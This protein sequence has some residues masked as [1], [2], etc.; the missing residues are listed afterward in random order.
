MPMSLSSSTIV[1]ITSILHFEYFLKD[2][3]RRFQIQEIWDT[4]MA[5]GF[6]ANL[7]LLPEKCQLRLKLVN[8]ISKY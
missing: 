5:K 7:Q 6:I 8:M 4:A 2:G 3:F 1:R